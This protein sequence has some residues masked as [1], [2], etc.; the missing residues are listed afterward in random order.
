MSLS[1]IILLFQTPC[2][3]SSLASLS[4][5]LSLPISSSLSYIHCPILLLSTSPVWKSQGFVSACQHSAQ[6]SRVE[7]TTTKK[8]SYFLF[9]RPEKLRKGKNGKS[10]LLSASN[11]K[12]AGLREDWRNAIISLSQTMSLRGFSLQEK[13]TFRSGQQW[14]WL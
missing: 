14:G 7:G 4:L 9:E 2:Q 1:A 6:E 5:A 11:C 13:H 12:E 10:G 8:K 3:L